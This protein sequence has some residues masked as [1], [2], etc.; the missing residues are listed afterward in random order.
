M[1][2]KNE[3]ALYKAAIRNLVVGVNAYIHMIRPSDLHCQ[4][5]LLVSHSCSENVTSGFHH[6]EEGESRKNR[7]ASQRRVT[8]RGWAEATILIPCNPNSS[9]PGFQ[10]LI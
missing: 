5:E 9:F 1:L 6:H 10:A 2:C 8:S 3:K 7:T 4:N